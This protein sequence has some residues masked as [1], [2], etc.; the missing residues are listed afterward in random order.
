MVKMSNWPPL[1]AMSVVT[2][3]RRTFSSSVTHLIAM[4]GFL[5][6]KSPVSPCIR[7]MSLL[8]TVAIVSVVCASAG[9][10]A[11]N[12]IAA[13][14]AHARDLILASQCAEH[15]FDPTL[16]VSIMLAGEALS[17]DARSPSAAIDEGPYLGMLELR[18][19][20]ERRAHVRQETTCLLRALPS[21]RNG[22]VPPLP[23]AGPTSWCR[24]EPSLHRA[25]SV[26]GHCEHGGRTPE[27]IFETRNSP[28]AAPVTAVRALSITA[29]GPQTRAWPS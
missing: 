16:P 17:T 27:R 22:H 9:P 26:S 1:V 20:P 23:T 11:R 18:T 12:A 13:I 10:E 7:I 3:W 14:A 21:T 24:S 29:P 6:V 4:P 2:R 8:L 28:E 5:A 25:C 15:L 19:V